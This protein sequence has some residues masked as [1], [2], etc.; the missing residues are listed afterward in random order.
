MAH[1]K[2]GGSTKLGR[3][4]AA[5]RLGVKRQEGQR[6]NAGEVLIRQRGTK[7]LP[8]QN[9]LKGKDDT[10]YAGVTGIVKFSTKNKIRFDGNRRKA[11]VVQIQ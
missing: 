3:E 8:G 11:T 4:S 2:S 5:K 10:L 6:V 1:T 7:Y 9:V